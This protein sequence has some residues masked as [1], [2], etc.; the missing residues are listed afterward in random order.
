MRFE[1]RNGV[2]VSSV[3]APMTSREPSYSLCHIILSRRTT[4]QASPPQ[5]KYSGL[6]LDNNEKEDEF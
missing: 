3:G 2:Y 5:H 6:Q 4:D 1:L